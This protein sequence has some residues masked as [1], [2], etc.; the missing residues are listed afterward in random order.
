MGNLPER[1]PGPFCNTQ[2][3]EEE[4]YRQQGYEVVK[5]K[6]KFAPTFAE[7]DYKAFQKKKKLNKG[8]LSRR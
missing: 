1:R 3:R 8:A 4:I 7:V 2:R 5:T 6:K